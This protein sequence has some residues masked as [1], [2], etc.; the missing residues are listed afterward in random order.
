MEDDEAR[1]E[2][3][4]AAREDEEH[5]AAVA[6]DGAI[7][8]RRERRKLVAAKAHHVKNFLQQQARDPSSPAARNQHI[9]NELLELYTR[10]DRIALRLFNDIES[11]S[12]PMGGLAEEDWA[13]LKDIYARGRELTGMYITVEGQPL[14]MRNP[15]EAPG[16][17][18][19]AAPAA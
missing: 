8:E 10:A 2:A 1:K 11:P 3:I 9:H 4:K 12:M 5:A 19:E 14:N 7:K 15:W 13:D 18:D 17:D 6:R 16:A